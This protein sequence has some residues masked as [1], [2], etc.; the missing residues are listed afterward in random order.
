MKSISILFLVFFLGGCSMKNISL[1]TDTEIRLNP[2][3]DD[4]YLLGYISS[5][6]FFFD[7]S[8]SKFVLYDFYVVDEYATKRTL[9]EINHSRKLDYLAGFTNLDTNVLEKPHYV[10]NKIKAVYEIDT[11]RNF[12]RFLNCWENGVLLMSSIDWAKNTES[13]FAI[14]EVYNFHPGYLDSLELGRY[15][16]II[17]P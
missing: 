17:M 6:P 13:R 2:K 15:Y 10:G 7:S 5:E 9:R 14:S 11:R 4:S 12:K 16:K 3:A 1:R 8:D